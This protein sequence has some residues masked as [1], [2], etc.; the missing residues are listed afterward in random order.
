MGLVMDGKASSSGRGS[1][2]IDV[3]MS[4]LAFH[5]GLVEHGRSAGHLGEGNGRAPA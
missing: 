5:A 2:R 1:G 4:S 3:G